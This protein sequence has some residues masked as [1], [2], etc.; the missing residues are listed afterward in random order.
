MQGVR[1]FTRETLSAVIVDI[2]SRKWRLHYNNQRHIPPEHP[3]ASTS[4]DVECF[5]SVLRDMVGR[6]FTH[7]E[8]HNTC[9][10][11]KKCLFKYYQKH[12]LVY[13]FLYYRL[14]LDGE[15]H[16]RS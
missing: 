12:V 15:K 1:G 13:V 10:V 14:C 3:R 8:V 11:R 16:A 2:E 6:D 9:P 5:F 4:D 7:K